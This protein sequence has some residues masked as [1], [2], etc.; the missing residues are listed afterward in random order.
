ML[1]GREVGG[2]SRCEL[3]LTILEKM[4]TCLTLVETLKVKLL[5]KVFE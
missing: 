2:Q 1:L 4:L 3:L 5:K